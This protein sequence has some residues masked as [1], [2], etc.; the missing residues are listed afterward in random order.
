DYRY[1][2]NELDLVA[3]AV[4][5]VGDMLETF[6]CHIAAISAEQN[7]GLMVHEVST[8]RMGASRA[9][10]YLNSWCQSWEVDNLFVTDGAAW[11]TS[12]YQNPTLTMMAMTVRACRYLAQ[13]LSKS[14][15]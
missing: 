2:D 13:R 4:A 12:A 3:D 5:S 6:G 14:S 10:S 7:P 9:S 15:L 1:S 8:P 11:P